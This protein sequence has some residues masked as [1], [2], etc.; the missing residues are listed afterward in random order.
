MVRLYLGCF[1]NIYKAFYN[2]LKLI[3]T[4]LAFYNLYEAYY[5]V[6]HVIRK[7]GFYIL[8]RSAIPRVHPSGNQ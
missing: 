6:L 2:L 1:Y 3:I 5:N 8:T 4:E 7:C